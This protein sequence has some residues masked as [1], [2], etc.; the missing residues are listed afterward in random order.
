MY[1]KP[2]ERVLKLKGYSET[3]IKSYVSHIRTFNN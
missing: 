1:S 3:T 2:L